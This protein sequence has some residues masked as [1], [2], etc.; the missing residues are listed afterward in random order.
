MKILISGHSRGIGLSIAEYFTKL[1]HE[2]AGYSRS[3]SKDL[4]QVGMRNQFVFDSI[5][6][7]I[8]VLNA[9][10]GFDSV[11]LLY[12]VC[13]VFRGQP[14]KTVVVIGSQST[15]TTK[16]FPHQY[17]IEKLSLESAAQQLQNVPGYPTIIVVRP[18]YVDTRTVAHVANLAKMSPDSVAEIGRAHV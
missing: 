18:G 9:N 8:V 12:Q 5:T 13:Q 11:N 3:N 7:D 2:V 14:G 6:S 1:G 10:I 4:A 16:N 15:E 17:Q